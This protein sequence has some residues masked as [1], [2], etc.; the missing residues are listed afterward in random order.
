LV[1][2]WFNLLFYF[3][4]VLMS[5]DELPPPATHSLG[6]CSDVMPK[7]RRHFMAPGCFFIE[8]NV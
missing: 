3:F 6:D 1:V 2:R 7:H 5:D 8:I 4:F